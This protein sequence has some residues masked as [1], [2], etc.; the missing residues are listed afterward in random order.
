MVKSLKKNVH[1]AMD[2]KCARVSFKIALAYFGG[3]GIV[4]LVYAKGSFKICDLYHFYY[5]KIYFLKGREAS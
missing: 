5:N 3:G 1:V 4:A 2:S